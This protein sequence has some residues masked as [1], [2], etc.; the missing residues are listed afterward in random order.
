MSV[1]TYTPSFSELLRRFRGQRRLSQA[2]LAADAEVSPRHL[3]FLE[4]GKARPSRD[5][6]LVLASA[7]EL[8]LR[9][10]NALLGAA[11]YAPAYREAPP[12]APR[13]AAVR[14]AFSWVMT[15][16]E[17]NGVAL[18]DRQW[19]V[20]D[21]NAPLRAVMTFLLDGP[22]PPRL[23]LMRAPFDPAL[24]RPYV[25]NLDALGPLLLERL[26]REATTDHRSAALLDEVLALPPLPRRG[27]A[28][29]PDVPVL[30]LVLQK[31]PIRLSTF[32]T[33]AAIGTALDP[34]ID[35]LRLETYFPADDATE[36][37]VRSLGPS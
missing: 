14:R 8:P 27:A 15:R 37:F 7:L 16:M 24:F 6:V 36:A 10:R 28:P 33:I 30:P 4:N 29:I 5:M 23:N 11:G 19:N 21:M 12:D 13:L 2:A 3:S 20:L 26:R 25:A 32:S 18:L 34:N 1:A 17:P 35:D 22:P 9:D 31:G